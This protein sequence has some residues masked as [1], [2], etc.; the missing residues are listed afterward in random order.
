MKASLFAGTDLDPPWRM[1][2]G[3][4]QVVSSLCFDGNV[5]S[6]QQRREKTSYK[7]LLIFQ[8][9][10]MPAGLDLFC[11]IQGNNQSSTKGQEGLPLPQRTHDRTLTSCSDTGLCVSSLPHTMQWKH[12]EENSSASGNYWWKYC[13]G[14]VWQDRGTAC[15]RGE[16]GLRRTLAEALPCR[17]PSMVHCPAHLPSPPP[18]WNPMACADTSKYI[19]HQK[20]DAASLL[21]A[22]THYREQLFTSVV[23]LRHQSQVSTSFMEDLLYWFVN[24]QTN[25][26]WFPWDV[27]DIFCC[28]IFPSFVC[29]YRGQG[30]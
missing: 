10:L 4:L 2:K 26:A 21:H 23:M 16:E 15:Q 7:S 19:E 8:G 5:G 14:L 30:K 6:A 13:H 17:T 25:F 11:F 18:W 20:A 22:I 12:T 9:M 24:R 3:S 1:W 29:I 28:K 27:I